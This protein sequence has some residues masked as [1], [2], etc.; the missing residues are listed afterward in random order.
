MFVELVIA[1]RGGDKQSLGSPWKL[2]DIGF[3]SNSSLFLTKQEMSTG[4]VAER[5]RFEHG[6]VA[7]GVRISSAMDLSLVPG[8]M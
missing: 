3:H 2:D 8:S 1:I 6:P 7:K 4:F 5:K